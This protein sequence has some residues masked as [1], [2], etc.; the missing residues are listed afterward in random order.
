MFSLLPFSCQNASLDS[1]VY[2]R[3]T[4][5]LR[6]RALETDLTPSPIVMIVW[7]VILHCCLV[8]LRYRSA[9]WIIGGT[10]CWNHNRHFCVSRLVDVIVESL[11]KAAPSKTLPKTFDS[12]PKLC[13]RASSRTPNIS[14]MPVLKLMQNQIHKGSI[15]QR[16]TTSTNNESRP[17]K[18]L[19]YECGWYMFWCLVFHWPGVSKL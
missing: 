3:L 18:L 2:G 4:G 7:V 13:G 1:E 6:K 16:M 9:S 19:L 11:G 15:H 12:Q 10:N 14:S 17:D 5:C 8:Y